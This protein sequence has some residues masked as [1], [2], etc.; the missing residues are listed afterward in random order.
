[1]IALIDNGELESL[2]K[3]NSE[4]G[5]EI[6]SR[7]TKVFDVAKYATETDGMI[8]IIS[9][10]FDPTRDQPSYT[11][12]DDG[13]IIVKPNASFAI[14]CSLPDTHDTKYY[15]ECLRILGAYLY[16]SDIVEKQ[17]DLYK[18]IIEYPKST[19]N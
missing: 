6:I 7:Y 4:Q 12:N 13:E 15:S 2:I 11:I 3:A 8:P 5:R 17:N 19:I 1:M 10:L 14:K 9:L 16:T 18:T